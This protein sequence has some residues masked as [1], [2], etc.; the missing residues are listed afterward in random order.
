MQLQEQIISASNTTL[1][2]QIYQTMQLLNIKSILK[3][4]NFIKKEKV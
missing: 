4:S 1:K 3:N 2:N